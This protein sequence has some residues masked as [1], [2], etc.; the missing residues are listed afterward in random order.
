MKRA[1]LL[2]LSIL[3][4]SACAP[5]AVVF[6]SPSYN[7]GKIRRVAVLNMTDYPDSPGS[8]SIVASTFEKY[9]LWGGYNLVERRQVRDVLKEQALTL[10]R[11]ADPSAIRNIG[12]ILGV[13]AVV[14]G[15]VTEFTNAREHT[16]MVDIPQEQTDPIYG[17]VVTVQ[18]QGD[19]MVKTVQNVVTG[20]NVTRTSQVVPETQTFPAHVAMSVRLVDVQTGEVLWSSSGSGEGVDL[21]SASENASSKIMQA[22]VKRLK[23]AGS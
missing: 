2:V 13:D 17:Q 10:S 4:I 15:D 19:T 12:K 9:L 14:L 8:G 18:R 21:G 3:A 16:V 6:I 1:G 11:A 5:P 7:G 22:L 20:Y 23:K